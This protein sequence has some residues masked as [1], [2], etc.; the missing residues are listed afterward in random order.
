MESSKKSVII[1][2]IYKFLERCGC[3]GVSCILKIVISSLLFTKDYWVLKKFT[4]F[5]KI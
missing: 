5:I 2:L 1:S 4:K 3:Q